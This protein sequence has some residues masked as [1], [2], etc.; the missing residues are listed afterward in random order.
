MGEAHVIHVTKYG[1]ELLPGMK[2]TISNDKNPTDKHKMIKVKALVDS[3]AAHS[4]I[5]EKQL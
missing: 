5:R 1:S 3:G 2:T 4:I